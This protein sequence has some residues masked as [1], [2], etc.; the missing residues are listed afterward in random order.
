MKKAMNNDKKRIMLIVPM[1]HQGGFERICA[2]TAKLLKDRYK[3]YLVVFTTKDMFYDVSGIEVIDLNMGAVDSRIGKVLNVFKRVNKLKKLKMELNI[4]ISYSFGMSA[5]LVNVLSK[6]C[7]VTWAGMRAYGDLDN[8]S[9]SKLI[10]TKAD[11]VVS[12]TKIMERDICDT[13]SVKASCTVYNPCDLE[14]LRSQAKENINSSF[15]NFVDSGIIISS[16]GREDDVKGFWHLIKIVYLVRKQLPQVKLT[17]IGDGEYT[18][19]K[20]LAKKLG[21]ERDVLFT[22]VQKN[23]FAILA[24]T[25]IYM[26]TSDSEGFPNALIEAMALGVPCVSVNCKTGPAEI[27]HR[28]YEKCIDVKDVFYADYGIITPVLKGKKDLEPQVFTKEEKIMADTVVKLI[29]DKELLNKYK[30]QGIKRADEFGM[31][32]YTKN[33]CKYIN[34]DTK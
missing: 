29:N 13:Y 9:K 2:L 10:A 20:E 3:I 1:L 33:I 12:C 34:E 23:P 30:E 7:D 19:Y 18:E 17:I 21:M 6:T 25:D 8:K 5:N 11:R 31:E 4:D 32:V 24:K 14:L 28:E 22:G 16:M 27:L 15:D 26:L